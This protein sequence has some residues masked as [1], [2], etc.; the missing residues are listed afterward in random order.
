MNFIFRYF[1]KKILQ[2]IEEEITY[3]VN[4]ELSEVEELVMILW[5]RMDEIETPPWGQ[6][7]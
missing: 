6:L 5:N 2:G 7:E 3:R 1:R 4:K